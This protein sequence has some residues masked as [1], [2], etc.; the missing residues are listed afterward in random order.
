MNPL[1]RARNHFNG[2]CE[3]RDAAISAVEDAPDT[4][5]PEDAE[6]LLEASEEA[7]R[8]VETYQPE[9]NRLER[10]Y[11]ARDN[12][13]ALVLGTATN[14]PAASTAGTSTVGSVTVHARAAGTSKDE[15]VYRPDDLGKTRFLR[16][17]YLAGIRGD[18]D[19]RARLVR[20]EQLVMEKRDVT[21]ADPGAAA[22]VPPRYLGNLWQEL[23][24]PQRVA[25]EL[26]PKF[27]IG[28]SGMSF[29]VPKIQTGTTVASQA[30]ENQALSETDI[31]TETLT[32][33][34]E[35][36]GGLQDVSLQSLERTDPALNEWVLDDMRRAYD[37]QV[38]LQFL[39]GAGHGS[40]ELPGLL[41]VSG[42]NDISWTETTPTGTT[43][44]KAVYSAIS[45][46]ASDTSGY[47]QA[48]VLVMHPRRAAW[49]A[50][51]TSTSAPIF[52][53]GGLVQTYAQ[54]T[55]GNGFVGQMAG[56][57]VY[58]SSAIL[59]TRGASTNQDVIFV[60]DPSVLRFG[61]GPLRVEVFRDVLSSTLEVRFRLFSYVASIAD[62][63]PAAIGN[64]EGTGLVV[65]S[66]A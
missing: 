17:V 58:Q 60:L 40:N 47:A 62:R 57:P 33:Y 11:E 48:S 52:Q 20:N 55:Q 4:T 43:G 44:L 21:T 3:A 51:Q 34:L 59:T 23:P 39:H 13:P 32:A 8:A 42:N 56:L 61:E 7:Q 26:A 1:E 16:D 66:F 25:V 38:E 18:Q 29:T 9:L 30:G 45:E 6:A 28:D 63:L 54:G 35:T 31:D 10:I 14:T 27:D 24:R 65:P 2:L 46:I 5:S 50:S 19:A 64:I 36:I 37:A 49:F 12:T 41:G 53:Q 15:E 22:F